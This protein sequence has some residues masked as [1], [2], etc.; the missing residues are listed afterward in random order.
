MYD[1]FARKSSLDTLIV[2]FLQLE[3]I[4]N[5]IVFINPELTGSV[6]IILSIFRDQSN[7]YEEKHNAF[8]F[9]ID[10]LHGNI[11]E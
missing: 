8:C 4:D 6:L 7:K 2:P 10:M 9:G 1:L 11:T 3:L 5:N